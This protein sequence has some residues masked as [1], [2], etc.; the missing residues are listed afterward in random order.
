MPVFTSIG[1][2]LGGSAATAFGIG[3][4]ATAIGAGIGTAAFAAGGGFDS[5]SEG[6][7]GRI[8]SAASEG[9]GAIT[10]AEASTAAK[11]RAFRSGVLFTSPTGLDS[12]PTTTGAKLR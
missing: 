2:A 8:S 9:T 4:G 6:I 5:P 10:A 12:D 7:D 1:L 11:K 3:V